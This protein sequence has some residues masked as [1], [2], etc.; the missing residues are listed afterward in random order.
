M[1]KPPLV[2]ISI[3]GILAMSL[4]QAGAADVQQSAGSELA[5]REDS[6]R[7]A[8]AAIA[9]GDQAYKDKRYDVAVVEYQAACDFLPESPLTHDLRAQAIQ[10]F[11]QAS[12]RLAEQRIAEGRYDEAETTVKTVLDPKYNPTYK[13]AIVLQQ[14][15]SDPDYFNRTVTPKFLDKIAWSR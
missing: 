3:I 11:S 4:L 10:D 5:R 15:L 1:T 8:Q 2:T 12:V 7:R 14:H 9:Q 6:V 13:D